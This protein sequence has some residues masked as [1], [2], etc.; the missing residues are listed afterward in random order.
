MMRQFA[1]L[2]ILA[3]APLWLGAERPPAAVFEGRPAVVL[4]NDNVEFT[5]LPK[6]GSIAGAVLK[7]D[8]AKLNPL[9]NP[10][11]LAREVGSPEYKGTGFG[12]WVC[13]DGFGT[14]SLEERIAGF[15]GHGEAMHLD[16]ELVYY[17]KVG[18]ATTAS[19]SV[20]LPLAQEDFSRTFRTV[21]G[22]NTL[23]VDSVL[24]SRVAFDRP[25]VW[26]EHFTVG[27]PF[28][29]PEVTVTDM[30]A[31]KARTR[32]YKPEDR[33]GPHR[34]PSDKD[35]TWPMAPLVSGGTV[36][37]RT[38]PALKGDTIDHSTALIDPTRE[39]AYV[40]VINPKKQLLIGCIFRRSEF[41]WV[42]SWELY[43][44]NGK[45]VR[46]LEFSTMAFD[47][48]RRAAAE[49]RLYGLPGYRWLPAKAKIQSRYVMFYVPT[50][51]GFTRVDDVKTTGGG[52]TLEDHTARKQVMV[53][54]SMPL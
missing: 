36:D 17:G 14:P 21:D 44:L 18:I 22:E 3:A 54:I 16:W 7:S 41:P 50:P 37:L 45:I 35:F 2:V 23:Y 38:P 6:G 31:V 4:S 33:G 25:A 11:R 10:A 13:V 19:F 9:W 43:P 42:Q 26:A 53:K 12:S 29:E 27:A 28:L 20:R 46:G 48:A 5:I 39:L 1:A 40:T 15:P 24:E 51:E 47:E 32:D 34:L 8:P 49:R 52:I 30:P